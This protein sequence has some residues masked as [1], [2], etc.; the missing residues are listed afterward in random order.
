MKPRL[1]KLTQGEVRSPI[2]LPDATFGVV[3]SVDSEDL[4]S[5]GIEALVMNTFHLM[6][7]P[8]SSTIQ[9]LG[10]LHKMSNWKRNIV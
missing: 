2:Y 1:L 6:Q 7:K 4:L 5:I 3:R 10:G 8:G 9:S